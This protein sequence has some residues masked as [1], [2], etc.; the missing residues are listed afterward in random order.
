MLIKESSTGP[1]AAGQPAASN[2]LYAYTV[3]EY[4]GA[5]GKPARA[6]TRVGVAFPHKD[7]TG[8]N[9]QLK[10]LPLD[11]RLV[12][13]PPNDEARAEDPASDAPPSPS[14]ANGNRRR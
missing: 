3:E 8:F 12:L 1:V 13:F 5:D 2:H 7:G 11:G 9:I 10:A 14:R 4:E 6:W